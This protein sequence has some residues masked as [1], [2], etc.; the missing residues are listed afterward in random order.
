MKKSVRNE[1]YPFNLA[2]VPL[3]PI[4]DDL[5]RARD[6]R[7]KATKNLTKEPAFPVSRI[8]GGVQCFPPFFPT[9][10]DAL[11]LVSRNLNCLSF[12]RV[13]KK[14]EDPSVPT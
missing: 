14:N 9:L 6:H 10:C 4:A 11:Q 1:D 7:P 3:F 13:R 2:V 5:D 8:A 12:D